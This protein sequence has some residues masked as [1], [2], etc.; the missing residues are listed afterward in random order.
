MSSVGAGQPPIYA[1]KAEFFRTLGHPVRIRLLQL[2]RDGERTV[3]CAAGGARAR[4]EQHVAAARGAA[5]AGPG[6]EPPRRDERLLPRQGSAHAGAARAGQADHRGRISR[7]ARRC[8][9]GSPARTSARRAGGGGRVADVSAAE[10]VAVAGVVGARARAGCSRRGAGGSAPGWPRRPRASALLGAMRRRRAV[11][12]RSRSARRSA[13][14]SAPALGLDPLSGFFLRRAGDHGAAGARVRPRATSPAGPAPRAV[15]ALT[16][17]FLLALAGLL[18]AR[19]VIDVPGLLGADDAGAGGGD[20][21]RAPRRRRSARRSSP[22]WRSRTSAAPASG[23]RCWRWPTTARS[24]TPR[25]SP[26][27]GAG[28]QTLVAV[29]A[30]VG[31]GTKAGLVPL[32]SWLP[33]AHPVAP[34]HLSALMSGVMIKVA[35]YGLI[36]VQFEWLGATPRWLG[37]R[38][39]G[40]RAAVGAGRRA[41]GARAARPQA[42]ARV[43]TRSRTS[44]SSR[45]ASAPRCC[46]PT[47]GRRDVGGDRVRRR[48]AARRQPRDLQGAAVPRRGRVRAG[49]RLARARPAR[50]AAAPHAVDGR[51][52]PGRLDGDRRAAAAQRLRVGVADAAVAAAPRARRAAGRRAG[53]RR[54]RS[55]ASRRPPRWRCCASCKVVGLVLLGPPR[56]RGVRERGR[57]AAPACAPGWPRSPRCASRS[58]SCP[59]SLVPTLTAL[60]PGARRGR[61]GPADAGLDVPGT[62]SLPAL[63]ARSSRSLV[64]HRRCSCALRGARRAAPAPTWAC[65]QPVDAGAE[66][67]VGR[68]HE[69]AAARARGGAAPAARDRGRR[70]SAAWCSAI[71]YSQRGARRSPTRCCTSRRSAPGCAARRSRAGCRPATCAPTRCTC[72]ALVLGLLALVRDGGARMSARRG[73]RRAGRRRRARAAAAGHDPDAQGAPAGPPRRLA[74]AALPRAAPALG[75]E[76]RRPERRR[77]RLPARAG[78]R[79]RL[80]CSSPSRCVPVGGRSGDWALGNDALVLVGLLALA[81]FALAAAAWDTGNGFALMGAARDLTLAVFGEALLV[82]AL[83]ARRAARRAAPTSSR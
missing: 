34:A 4:L 48:A 47:P 28:A 33:R 55:P 23:S 53:R 29:A 54:S 50:R 9:T 68:L 59:G 81:R 60:A 22:T 8:S 57:G 18:A 69:A 19:D 3:G 35:L 65:G 10:A 64:A 24:A 27:Q 66:L 38:V 26:P 45:S 12:R 58:A 72:S 71:A 39:A 61:A 40:A 75:Q 32:H 83:L 74:A 76:R 63:G 36:R 52:V 82:L 1:L 30:L 2:L 80:R 67:D 21:R 11:R 46:S 5:Q 15:G 25:R 78:A 14:T 7:R 79:G 73:R 49:G 41:V 42:A 20:P 62:G 70:R 31:F 37:H 16:A 6:R 51:R 13:A 77:R 56:R 44:G 43:L 17:A